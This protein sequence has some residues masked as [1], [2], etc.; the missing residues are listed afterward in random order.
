MTEEQKRLA[1]KII[2]RILWE[3]TKTVVQAGVIVAVTA[4]FKGEL[5]DVSFEELVDGDVK[6]GLL[7]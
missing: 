4:F 1:I 2:K 6:G 5:K 7:K 3:G